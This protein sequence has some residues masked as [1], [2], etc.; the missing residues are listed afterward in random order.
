MFR[1][2][3][4]PELKVPLEFLLGRRL[5]KDDRLQVNRIES[6]RDEYLKSDVPCTILYGPPGDPSSLRKQMPLQWL[7]RT[8]SIPRYWGIFLY[9]CANAIHA[10]TI[11]EFGSC[12]GISGS[13]LSS[14]SACEK[15]YTMEGSPEVAEIAKSTLSRISNKATLIRSDFDGALDQLLPELRSGIDLA[16]IDG[17]HEKE[18]TLHY[19]ERLKP[20]MNRGSLLVFDDICWSDEMEEAWKLICAQKG[21]R[22]AIDLGRFGLCVWDGSADPA[23]VFNLSPYTRLWKKGK[24]KYPG[25]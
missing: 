3:L 10:K 24:P 11:L 14:A 21:I 4:A 25:A 9:L 15:F 23:R 13:Y 2:G 6:I 19:L 16:F 8:A 12:V 17:H 1:Q 7:A 20:H 22:C 18:P 5:E